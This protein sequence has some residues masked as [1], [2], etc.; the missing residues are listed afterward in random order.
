MIGVM[1]TSEALSLARL[2]GLDLVEVSPKALPPVAKILSFDKY[3]YQLEKA[4]RQQRK[5]QKEVEIKGIRLSVRIGKHD[6]ELKVGQAKKFLE[7]GNRVKIDLILRGREKA[8]LNFAF[9]VMKKFLG[10]L[11]SG[12]VVEQEPKK[13]GRVI[14]AIVG[15]RS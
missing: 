5:R 13:L 1:A 12:I 14:T 4:S 15:L 7:R 9:E 6:M 11:E 3:R 10:L 8:N 2:K